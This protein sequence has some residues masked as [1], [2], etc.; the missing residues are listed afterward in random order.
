MYP[1][2]RLTYHIQKAKRQPRMTN[3]FEETR[4]KM[5][6]WPWD[7]DSFMEMN[8]GR[9]LT[10]MDSGRFVN[11]IRTDLFTTLKEKKWGLMV[12]G[13]STRFRYRLRPFEKFTLHTQMICVTER[14]FYFH[15][16]F[17]SKN[18]E[19]INASCLVRTAVTSKKGLVP[20]SDVIATMGYTQEEIIPF[21]Q[22]MDWIKTWEES[23]G[24]HR[25]VMESK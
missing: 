25:T 1:Y 2:F 23:D 9:Y 14:W 22:H 3:P 18:G 12:G 13:V 24:F 16:W 10:V 11:G 19:K 15:Q 4:L 17:S 7:I 5:R 20:T 8:N 6:V 21:F